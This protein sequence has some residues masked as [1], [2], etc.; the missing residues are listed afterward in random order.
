MNP[1]NPFLILAIVA[2]LANVAITAA[3]IGELQKR[4]VKIRWWL[5]RILIPKYIEQY[6]QLT[7]Q[8]TGEPGPFFNPWLISINL[9]WIFVLCALGMK[10]WY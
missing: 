10:L 2:C 3:I 7:K 4:G 1:A 9:I 5:L 8:E 6:K